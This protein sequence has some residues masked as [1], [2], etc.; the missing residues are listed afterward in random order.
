M[1]DEMREIFAGMGSTL[2]K[3]VKYR[4]NWVFVGRAGA[5]NKGSFEKVSDSCSAVTFVLFVSVNTFQKKKKKSKIS[6]CKP[7][8]SSLFTCQHAVNDEKTN[9]YE[10][11]PVMV[12]L[13]GCFP[14]R[15]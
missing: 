2:I 8:F 6:D 11:W 13:G 7:M 14:P 3:S 4:D 12:E 15:R 1:T 10:G 9:V 5:G